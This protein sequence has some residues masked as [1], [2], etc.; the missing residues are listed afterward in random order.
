[1]ARPPKPKAF[2]SAPPEPP[3]RQPAARPRPQ[4]IP[5]AVAGR[6]ARRIALATGV[7]SVL[8]MGVFVVSYLLVSR[9]ILDIP[10]VVTLVSSGACFLL[11]LLGLSYGVLSASWEEKAGSLLG[12]EHIGLN[13]GRVRESLRAMRS[14][15]S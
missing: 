2:G 6:M 8:G 11:G 4:V 9:G 12:F 3:R 1:M 10:P 14:G 15:S 13:I 5:D 7:P